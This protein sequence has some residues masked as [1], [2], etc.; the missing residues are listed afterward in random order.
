MHLSLEVATEL[1]RIVGERFF[2]HNLEDLSCYSYDSTHLS[3]YPEAVVAPADTAQI[4]EILRI[5][6][7]AGVPIIARGNGTSSSGGTI[8][9]HGGVVI[10][11][12]RFNRILEIDTGNLTATV[13]PGVINVELQRAVQEVG[14]YYPPDPGSQNLSTLGGNVGEN[15]G[16]PRCFKYGV[17]RDYV[18][19]LEVVLADGRIIRTG[20]KTLKN[21]SGYDLTR[22]FV[23]SEGTLGIVTEITVRL[24]P[25]PESKQTLLAAFG[26]LAKAAQAVSEIIAN[27]IVP[28]T[29]E[30]M[31]NETIRLIE[32]YRASGLP[33]EAAGCLLI[34]IDGSNTEVEKHTARVAEICQKC[35]GTVDVAKSAPESDTLWAGRRSIMG[36]LASSSY[37]MITED[38]VVPRTRLV[39]MVVKIKEIAQ[40]YQIRIPTAGH[41]GD[42]NLHPCILCD[43]TDKAEMARVE[44]AIQEIFRT[45][46]SMGGT[47][48][49]EHGIGLLKR[50]FM[51]WEHSKE[52]LDTMQSIKAAL[53]PNNI[54]NPG[55]IFQPE[56]V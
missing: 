19:G 26:D 10:S 1:R 42:G 32:A 49:G 5:A 29:L 38:I 45:A 24:I 21:V 51:P 27:R 23:G 52:T 2:H 11:M 31:D 16:G 53:D 33:L 55:K 28:T 4:S 8:P 48:S 34:D 36:A 43:D 47:L 6:N 50:Q 30:L 15:A 56:A 44:Q 40:R 41:A 22:L 46:L 20:G 13:Q 39:D 54:L 35:G 12:H 37:T 25:W 7:A 17:T 18:L 9:E 14:L 3:A